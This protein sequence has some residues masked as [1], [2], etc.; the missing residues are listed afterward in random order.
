MTK[1]VDE[2]IARAMCAESGLDPDTL[3]TSN[4]DRAAPM[5]MNWEM[6]AIAAVKALTSAGYAIVPVEPTERMLDHGS[7]YE[8]DDVSLKLAEGEVSRN[9]WKAMIEASFPGYQDRR[10]ALKGRG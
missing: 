2:I 3:E 10:D 9:V 6:D 8:D 7:Y 4:G 5:W 1:T